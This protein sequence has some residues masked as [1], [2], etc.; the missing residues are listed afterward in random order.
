MEDDMEEARLKEERAR[1]PLHDWRPTMAEVLA[2]LRNSPCGHI[3]VGGWE[4]GRDRGCYSMFMLRG[5]DG[6]DWEVEAMR[7]GPDYRRGLGG[8]R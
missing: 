6:V 5:D 7:E 8:R 3:K 2:Y 4:R 1:K